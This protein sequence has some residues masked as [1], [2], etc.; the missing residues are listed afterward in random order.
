M[1]KEIRSFDALLLE[2]YSDLYRA[3]S[4]KFPYISY[5]RSTKFMFI[6][7]FFALYRKYVKHQTYK[8][9]EGEEKK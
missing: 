6:K 5:Y 2:N 1:I 3:V 8:I 7:S 4:E 9:Q